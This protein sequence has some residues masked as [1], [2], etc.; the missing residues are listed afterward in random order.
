M[1]LQ[2]DSENL[3]VQEFPIQADRKTEQRVWM[4]LQADSEDS[5]QS[6]WMRLQAD[7]ED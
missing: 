5:D 7:S 1:R 2:A 3:S 4:R 6:A